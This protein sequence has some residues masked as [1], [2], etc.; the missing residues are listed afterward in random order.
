MDMEARVRIDQ[1][2]ALLQTEVA[3]AKQKY[4]KKVSALER[5]LDKAHQEKRDLKHQIETQKHAFKL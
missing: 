5:E 4:I 3:A 1:Q 2:R